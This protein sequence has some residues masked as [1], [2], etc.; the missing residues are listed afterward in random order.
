MMVCDL[1]P[2]L[3]QCCR[4]RPPPQLTLEMMKFTRSIALLLAATCA[5][6][7][8]GQQ[9]SA[10]TDVSLSKVETAIVD[11][12]NTFRDE[13]GLEPLAVDEDLEEAATQFAEFMAKEGKYGHNA[14]GRTPAERARAAG[15]RYCVVRENIAYRTNTATVTEESLIEIFVQG[16][17]DSPSHREN[18][19]ATYATQTGVAVATADGETFYAVQMFGR[20]QSAAI[21]IMIENTTKNTYTLSIESE[22]GEDTV[23]LQPR[24]FITS[25]RC[26]PTTLG[27]DGETYS[28]KIEESASVRIT[29]QG[30]ERSEFEPRPGTSFD[31]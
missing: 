31:N 8:V 27:L 22:G 3:R 14:D 13:Q 12:T 10:V 18:M 5:P 23:D 28:L 29:D 21:Q 16:W 19:L 24:M 30:F 20:P 17:I 6:D 1:H 15:Y 25:R 9:P 26:Y 2:S 11:Q 4:N 7:V